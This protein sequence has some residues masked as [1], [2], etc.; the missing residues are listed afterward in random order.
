MKRPITGA[1]TIIF[2]TDAEADRAFFRDAGVAVKH[3][4]SEQA[5]GRLA[6]IVLPGGGEV[7]IYEPTHP[8][9]KH[10]SES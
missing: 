5:W 7:S 1:H 8:S 10:R 9:P 3:A 6:S 2:S 4:I